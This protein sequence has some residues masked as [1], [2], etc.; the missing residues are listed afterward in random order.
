MNNKRIYI[1]LLFSLF[2]VAVGISIW[3]A[4]VLIRFNNAYQ[5]G[6]LTMEKIRLDI[7]SFN[8]GRRSPIAPVDIKTSALDG[9]EQ[10][11]VPEGDFWMGKGE[12]R[13]NA[14]SPMH[15]IHLDAFWMDKY[16]VSNAMYLKCMQ[17][18]ACTYMVSDN[19]TY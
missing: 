7:A 15:S 11:Y 18:G 13:K 12:V 10:V 14:D 5:N 6:T 8:L 3:N 17:A 1:T 2:T 9:M 4:D 16:E 19:I